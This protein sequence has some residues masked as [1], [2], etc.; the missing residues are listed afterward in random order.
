MKLSNKTKPKKLS[1]AMERLVG[2]LSN[3]AIWGSRRANAVKAK[4]DVENQIRDMESNLDRLQG[5][6]TGTINGMLDNDPKADGGKILEEAQA[7]VNENIKA[8]QQLSQIPGLE[9]KK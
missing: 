5:E 7:I 3:Q 8:K 2:S 1:K 6:I 4:T 9:K